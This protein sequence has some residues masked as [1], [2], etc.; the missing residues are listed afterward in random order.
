MNR[1]M[2]S[3]LLAGAAWSAAS[4]MAMA[5]DAAPQNDQTALDDVVVTARRRD[6]QLKDVPVAVSALSAE[7]LERTGAADI[8]ALQQQTPNATVQIARGSNSTLI[9]FIRGVGQQDPL[10]GFE[11]GVGL[12]IDDV[13]VARPQGAVLDIFDV[14]RIEVLRGP[15]GTLYGRNTIGG[16]IKYVTKRLGDEFAF[17][18]RGTIGSYNQRDALVS[19]TIPLG[20]TFAVGG[21]FA[22]YDRDGFGTNLFTGEEQYDKDVT[23]YRASAEWTPTDQLFVRFAWDRVEDDSAPRH[24]HREVNSTTGG[25]T[26]PANIYD[27]NAGVQ[28]NQE[29]QTQGT[30]VTVE[31]TVNDTLTLKSISAWRSGDTATVIDFDQ[32]PLPFLDVPAVYADEQFTQEFQALMQGDNWSGVAGL[33]YLDGKS[34]GVFDTIAGNLGLAIAAAGYV[35]TESFSAYA[36][37]SYDFSDR[38][39]AS[40]GGRYTQDKK[41]A[42]VQRFFYLGAARSPL[43]GG[44]ARPIFATRTN[45]TADDTFEKF[46]PRASISYDLTEE[47]TGYA[48]ISQGFKSGGW[49]MRGDAALVPSTVNG[50]QPET[51]TTY[52]LGLKGTAF[53]R[54]MSFASAAFY[55]D[56]QD[57]Q[58]TTQQVATLPAVGIASVVDNAGASTIYGFEFEGRAFITDSITSNVS[59]G[60]LKNEFDRFITRV[61]GAPVDISNLREPQNSPEWSA[62]WGVTWTGDVAGGELN[63]TPSISY[64]SDYHLFDAPDPILDQDAY[65]LVDLAAIWTAPNGHYQVA[66][67]GRNLTDEEY[68]VGGYNFAGA[69]FNNSISAFYGPPRTFS[70][71]VTV[72]Y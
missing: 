55:S 14:N 68:K 40:L 51:V 23:A 2:K 61:T 43:T 31:Y 4:S 27:T 33:Y 47:M 52:E 32:T 57:Q 59:V 8:T 25:Y 18:G 15:Q 39:H 36:D 34:S 63:I 3:V 53:D 58:I 66:L 44:T 42:G 67:T 72:R 29:V 56:F 26:P 41:D 11:P 30:S 70:A 48:S 20:E 13:Y 28:G 45:Y 9:S 49:D 65:T 16:A 22:K 1:V 50:Y 62:F 64:R 46:T 7:Q 24:G 19:A 37:F 60:Y 54:R 69:T 10:W 35:N 21:A 6:E 5:Q 71:S 17:M 38:L 12:Y